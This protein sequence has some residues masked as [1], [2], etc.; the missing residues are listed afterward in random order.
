MNYNPDEDI[1]Y[2]FVFSGII[3]I[4]GLVLIIIYVVKLNK[5]K[6]LLEKYSDKIEKVLN[7]MITAKVFI[8]K[9]VRYS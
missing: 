6:K 1:N 2:M 3:V 9:Y 8:I 5:S 4:V 7:D